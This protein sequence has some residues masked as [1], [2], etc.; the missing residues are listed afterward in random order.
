MSKILIVDDIKLNCDLLQAFLEGRG[1]EVATAS[2]GA[3]ALEQARAAPPDLIV[4]DILMP[5]MDGFALCREWKRDEDL[6]QVPF[7]FYTATYTDAKDR[8]LAEQL[9]AERFLIKPME[10][11]AFHS[12]I[13]EVLEEA[14]VAKLAPRPALAGA[15]DELSKAY[16]EALVRKLEDKMLQLQDSESYFR[17][18]LNQLHE[19]VMVIDRNYTIT[20]INNS[21]LSFADQPREEVVGR[22]C[23]E[24][25]HG[26]DTPCTEHGEQC[27]LQEV[28]D[29]G[30][31]RS[32][33]HKHTRND[34]STAIVDIAYT[35]FR[36]GEGKVTHVIESVR[37]ISELAS[38]KERVEAQTQRLEER[39]KELHCLIDVSSAAHQPGTTIHGL[40]QDAISLI[41]QGWQYPEITVARILL[42]DQKFTSEGFCE[43]AWSQS[44]DLVVDGNRLGSIEVFYLEEKPEA[45]EGP[46]LKE[47]RDLIRGIANIIATAH[48]QFTA[49]QALR[50]SEEKLRLTFE[51]ANEGITVTDLEG[52]IVQANA[53]AA[54]LHGYESPECMI[55]I[56][57]LDLISEPDR[58]RAQENFG[59]ALE[60][61]VTGH[62][63]YTLRRADGSHFFAALSVSL[64]QR[65]TGEPIGFVAITEDITERRRAQ[66]KLEAA[67][68]GALKAL[69]QV[70]EARDP[71]TSGHQQRVAALA[72]AIAEH[73]ELSPERL[74]AIHA[75]GLMHD[76]GKVSI[77]AEL[78]SKPSRLSENEME[79]I[80]GH[81]QV[82]HDILASI[83]FPWDLASIV[84]QHHERVDGAGYPHGLKADAI[85]LESRILAVAD[86]VEAM[87]S[88]RPY[89]P[90]LGI[91][92]AL[93]EIA[94][95]RG[96]RYD[97]DVVEACLNVFEEGFDWQ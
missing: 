42:N 85:L 8:S 73:M 59:R 9:G 86:A 30:E 81:A 49:Q 87:S 15:V 43:T 65:M 13:A 41:Q 34:G 67:F 48:K 12:V 39:V 93:E 55:G 33:L 24:V 96:K 11:K 28:F 10:L 17:A 80:K 47:E 51:A 40:A 75:A 44:E 76:I 57:A 5:V 91:G 50:E 29:T 89:R 26:F 88:H 22:H 54:R 66:A 77:P 38:A 69:G 84:L 64:I 4:S 71:Y 46:F 23:Y 82:G 14:G 27:A 95:E 18:L 79:F 72:S 7:V 31:P 70:T 92:H 63:E 32:A 36:N 61:G 35:P 83:E 97:S 6:S 56:V 90:A 19:D 21:L 74:A 2:N 53:A 52:I 60:Q 62:V 25:S 68:E 78:L 45:D 1:H 58:P 3:E 94:E 16:N 20:D 37:D